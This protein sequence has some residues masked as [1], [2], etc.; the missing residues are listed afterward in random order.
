MFWLVAYEKPKRKKN[1]ELKGYTKVYISLRIFIINRDMMTFA[2]YRKIYAYFGSFTC[3]K[4]R[5]SNG[6][7]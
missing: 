1:E 6:I 5:K 3:I 4:M 7:Q 2:I